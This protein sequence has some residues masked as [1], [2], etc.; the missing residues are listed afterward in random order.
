M[1]NLFFERIILI[2]DFVKIY[3]INSSSFFIFSFF[4]T[5]LCV[6]T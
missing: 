1:F 3:F 4:W 6:P 5:G 2:F